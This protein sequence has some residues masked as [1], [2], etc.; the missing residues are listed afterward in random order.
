MSE[1]F[2]VCVIPQRGA[3]LS[4][5]GIPKPDTAD[6]AIRFLFNTIALAFEM[7]RWNEYPLKNRT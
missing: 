2:A 5:A 3:P 6:T 4:H 1:A 7:Q